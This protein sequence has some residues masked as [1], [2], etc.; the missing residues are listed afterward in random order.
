[1]FFASQFVHA[2]A[3]CELLERDFATEFN[4]VQEVQGFELRLQGQLAQP[5]N[6]SA[7]SQKT[8]L[9]GIQA[10]QVENGI[11]VRHLQVRNDAERVSLSFHNLRY[12]RWADFLALF[13]RLSTA[14]APMLANMVVVAASLHYID[15]MEWTHPSQPM[16]LLQIYQKNTAYLPTHFF[17][18]SFSELLLTVPSQ[19]D[20]LNF[21]DRL[22]ITSMANNRPTATISHN[23]V[24]QFTEVADLT[25]LL[26]QPDL[27]EQPNLL[28]HVL[29]QA[30]EHNKTVLRGILQPEI[31]NLIGMTS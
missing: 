17:D 6:V 8:G 31:Q 14:L 7:S 29:Q 13:Q 23:L 21:F 26:E 15:E 25:A 2:K 24:H 18:S 28:Q 22:H 1:M 3:L 4:Q 12:E 27:P 19:L 20:G 9:P 16:P 5:G 30:H 10:S 11:I